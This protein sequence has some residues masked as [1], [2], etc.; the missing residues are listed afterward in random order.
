MGNPE[1]GCPNYFNIFK[2]KHEFPIAKNSGE[3]LP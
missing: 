1:L 3:A 2:K